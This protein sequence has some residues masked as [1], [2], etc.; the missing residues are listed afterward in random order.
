MNVIEGQREIRAYG[1]LEGSHP[2][3]WDLC[4]KATIRGLEGCHVEGAEAMFYIIQ[5]T[6]EK[7]V[8]GCFRKVNLGSI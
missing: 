3:V 6:E 4:G 2:V 5:R 7:P 8:S 1:A